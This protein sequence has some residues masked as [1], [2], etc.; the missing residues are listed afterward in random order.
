MKIYYG[1]PAYMLSVLTP[2][3]VAFL[4]YLLLRGKSRKTQ[5]YTLLS[6]MLL[7]VFQHL[8]KAVI[9]PHHFG[10]GFSI[11]STAYNMCA[12]L[13][14]ISPIAFLCFRSFFLD[15]VLLMGSAAGLA[16]IL[17]PYWHI[18]GTPFSWEYLRYMICHVL[19]FTTSVLPIALGHHRPSYRSI[20]F[21]GIAFLSSI[22]IIIFNY[23]VC[24]LVGIFRI[25]GVSTFYEAMRVANP[26][27]AFGPP[28]NFTSLLK[29]SAHFSPDRWVYGGFGGG[30]VPI[31]WYSIP[32]YLVITAFAIPVCI[33]ADKKRFSEDLNRYLVST[34]NQKRAE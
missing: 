2:I 20:P 25:D 23:A 13:I 11:V 1:S 12:L 22:I 14:I 6:V 26:V 33:F 21:F 30:P 27:W 28:E 8:F 19:L 3:A 31:L 24:Y 7:N 10:E 18:G 32:V 17:I 34:K 16:A 9:Y 4:T 29:A 15:F 5:K